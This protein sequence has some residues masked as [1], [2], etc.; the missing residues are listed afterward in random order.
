MKLELEARGIREN[1]LKL[2]FFTTHLSFDIC[3]QKMDIL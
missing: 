1:E 3:I 2:K